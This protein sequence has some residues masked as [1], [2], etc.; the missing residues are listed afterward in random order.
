MTLGGLELRNQ[1]L[2]IVSGKPTNP[3]YEMPLGTPVLNSQ[4]KLALD[5]AH[6]VLEVGSGTAR[7]QVPL[8]P[9]GAL[10]LRPS[11]THVAITCSRTHMDAA[12]RHALRQCMCTYRAHTWC[13]EHG[14]YTYLPDGVDAEQRSAIALGCFLV[15]VR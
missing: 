9:P 6:G 8:L 14:A 15:N 3:A 5:T 2:R 12:H 10:P 7:V 13:S 11:L 1:D 4:R